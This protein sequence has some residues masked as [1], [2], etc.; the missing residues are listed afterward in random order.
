[1][2]AENI[3]IAHETE[4]NEA[5]EVKETNDRSQEADT[6]NIIIKAIDEHKDH[7]LVKS[8]LEKVKGTLAKKAEKLENEHSLFK[9]LKTLMEAVEI[10][11]VQD[12]NKK[13]I[14]E[15]VLRSLVEESEMDDDK[16]N[17][18]LTLID[19]GAVGDTIDIIVAATKGELDINKKTKKRLVACFGNCIK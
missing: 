13:D 16:K 1:M 14:V 4:L 7:S 5:Q 10:E 17:I 15:S 8:I 3:E 2:S 19:S 18:C 6:I 11:D 9:F 12:A